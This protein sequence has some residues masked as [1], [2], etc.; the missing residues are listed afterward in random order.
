MFIY[1]ISGRYTKSIEN[2]R[3]FVPFQLNH[4]GEFHSYVLPNY[5][6][7]NFGEKTR[8]KRNPSDSVHYALH[9]NDNEKY[10]VELWPNHDFMSPN[11]VFETRRPNDKVQDKMI[12]N[13]DKRHFCH[14]TGQIRGYPNSKVAL[15]TCNGLV[16]N[17]F[18]KKSMERFCSF[19]QAG[20]VSFDNKRY[21]IE[22]VEDHE[23]NEFG[24]HL[25]VV[26]EK[27]PNLQQKTTYCGTNDEKWENIWKKRFKDQILM[28]N[29]HNISKRGLTSVH[30][31]L[32]T[33]VV[34]DKKFLDHHKNTDYE[35]YVLTVMN[36][37]IK[38]GGVLFYINY[39]TI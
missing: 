23:P 28:E 30:R 29:Q 27:N 25:H 37:V 10:H 31:Y 19:F 20:Y 33:L 13:L 16:K 17:Y 3:V 39:N 36:M 15:S 38:R 22:P 11:L 12:R 35:Q 4:I 32:E 18:L 34:C 14:Y 8:K 2:F 26:Y 24:Q 7:H 21:F 1:F 5:Y 6:K 9:L